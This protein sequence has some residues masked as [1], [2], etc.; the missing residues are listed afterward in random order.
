[1]G[2]EVKLNSSE[3]IDL[4]FEGKNKKYGAYFLR[5]TSSRR[6]ITA[7]FVVL[8]FTALVAYLPTL[9][10]K[11]ASSRRDL[12]NIDTTV[13]LSNIKDAE[14]KAKEE[15]II[16]QE[17]APPPPVLKATIQFTPPVIEED[18]KVKDE[19]L[20]RSQVE[21]NERKEQISVATVVGV[22]DD[23][24]AIDPEDLKEQK[25]ITVVQDEPYVHVEQMP[26]FPGGE[27]ELLKYISNNIRYPQI[28]TENGIQ[29]KVVVKFVVETDGSVGNVQ[30]LQGRD[31][32][33]D[34]EAIR[35]IKTL[36]KWV[37][38]RHN[39]IPVRVYFTL[40]VRFQLQ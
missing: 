10:E 14:D 5:S 37:P 29:G 28:A 31:R 40:P 36:P 4:V 20:M 25:K 35:V 22:I 38:G 11:V 15:E 13:E 26:Q 1:M 33:L 23:P 21:M 8:A 18:D 7:L 9:I 17:T 24:N 3:W 19:E 30:I 32:S 16:R 2:K 6:H 39:G 12:G 27:K 34:E